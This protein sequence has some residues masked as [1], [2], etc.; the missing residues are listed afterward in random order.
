MFLVLFDQTSYFENHI[1]SSNGSVLQYGRRRNIERVRIGN[2]V[3]LIFVASKAVSAPDE[4]T[5]TKYSEYE[6]MQMDI[7]EGYVS[8]K[9]SHSRKSLNTS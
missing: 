8:T 9:Y 1:P 5:R 3:A 4:R 6:W 2:F 7:N